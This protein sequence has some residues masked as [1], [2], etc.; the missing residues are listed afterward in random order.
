MSSIVVFRAI[1][2]W[3]SERRRNSSR[4][5]S[6]CVSACGRGIPMTSSAFALPASAAGALR[7]HP[8]VVRYAPVVTI[9]LALIAIWYVAAVMMNLLLVRGGLGREGAPDTVSG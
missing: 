3:K 5:R 8:L 2:T 6:V 9:V 1:A 7:H 4:S